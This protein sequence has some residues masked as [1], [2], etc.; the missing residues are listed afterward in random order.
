MSITGPG[1]R[2][3]DDEEKR[4]IIERLYQLWTWR[5]NRFLRLG[6]LIGNVYHSTDHGGVTLY[7]EEDY[8]LLDILETAYRQLREKETEPP[9]FTM[10]EVRNEQAE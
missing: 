8:P 4:E 1:R 7:Y 9:V 6:Q 10:P 2:A 3:I 5:G